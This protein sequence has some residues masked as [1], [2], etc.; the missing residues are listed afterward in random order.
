MITD[1]CKNC[2]HAIFDET[3]G[4]YKC[5]VSKLRVYRIL[6]S[7]ECDWYEKKKGSKE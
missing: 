1:S 7:E 3:W 5:W 2:K 6:T 4:E